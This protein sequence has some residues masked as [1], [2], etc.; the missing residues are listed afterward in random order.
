MH[1]LWS[2][3]EPRLEGDGGF[4]KSKIKDLCNARTMDLMYR[5]AVKATQGHSGMQL[6]RK[7]RGELHYPFQ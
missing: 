2:A 1:I 6:K 3:A 4:L 7:G 5:G